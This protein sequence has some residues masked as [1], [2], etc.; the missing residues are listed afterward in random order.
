MTGWARGQQGAVETVLP[1]LGA[2]ELTHS[3]PHCFLFVKREDRE[4]RKRRLEEHSFET[5]RPSDITQNH[6]AFEHNGAESE[7]HGVYSLPVAQRLR[8]QGKP[9]ST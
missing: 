4:G 5:Q 6:I 8:N 7:T 1:R 9:K 2:V 3:W